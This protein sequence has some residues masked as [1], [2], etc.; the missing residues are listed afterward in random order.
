[1][2]AHGIA[3]RI[4][5]PLPA[6]RARLNVRK[7]K[8]YRSGRKLAAAFGHLGLFRDHV[9]VAALRSPSSGLSKKYLITSAA[10]RAPTHGPT[11]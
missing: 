7:Q 8:C 11:A 6:A 5:I 4:A 9:P 1:M 2:T 10:R 3:H